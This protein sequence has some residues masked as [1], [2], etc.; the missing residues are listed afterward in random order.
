MIFTKADAFTSDD[1]IDKVNMEFSIHYKY[2][3]RS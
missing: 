1:K 2:C 3:I